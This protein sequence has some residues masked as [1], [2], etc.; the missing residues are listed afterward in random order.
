MAR[1]LHDTLAHTLSGL[2]VQLEAVSALWTVNP[3]QARSM[4]EKSLGA[5]RSGLGETRR[6][7][8]ALRASPLED[9]G[10]VRALEDLAKET[11]G[12]AGLKLELELPPDIE[13]LPNEAA[14]CFYR[15]GQEAMENA[16]RHGNG[17]SL[18]VKLS[19]DAAGLFMEIRDDG[20]G[21]DPDGVD[22]GKHFGLKGMRERAELIHASL[23]IESRSSIGTS[24]S[25][26]WHR[27]AGGAG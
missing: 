17:R 25:L 12:R 3:E 10:L 11:A 16:V 15:I 1:E 19:G 22:D 5:T 21:F 2:A 23:R 8:Q 18:A 4:V 20:E 7:I 26:S 27:Q 6:A 14:H 24:L 13:G 9:L